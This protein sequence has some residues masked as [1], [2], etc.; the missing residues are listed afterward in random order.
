MGNNELAI[1]KF[2]SYLHSTFHIKDLGSPKYFLG[3]EIA[4]SDKGISLSQRKFILEIVSE[5]GLSGCK[6]AIIPIEQNTKLTTHEYD[7]SSSPS[8][9]DSL[10]EDPSVY[11]RLVGKLIYLTMTR[12]DICYAVQILSQFMHK[13]KQSHMNAALKVVKYLKGC[14]GLGIFLSRDCDMKMMAYCDTD[15]ATCPMTRRSITGF[16]IKIGKSLIS[17]KTK[18]QSTVSL[19]SAESEYRAMAKTVCEIIWIR[20]L[21]A[22]LGVQVDGPSKLFCDNDAALKLAANPVFHE[23][24]KHI[25]VDCHFTRDK[26]REGVITTRGIGTTEQLAD[27]FTKPLCHRQHAYLLSKLGVLDIYRPPA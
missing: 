26:I 5:A 3:I 24:T 1:A 20:G 27:I 23:R 7:S 18:K 10:L 12:P 21:L 2:K 15:Y 11:Q 14:P 16:C 13:P 22:D 9:D 4:R 17:W 25:E 6:P 19:S 8:I